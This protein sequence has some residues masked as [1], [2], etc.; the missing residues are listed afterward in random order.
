MK[1]SLIILIVSLLNAG[2]SIRPELGDLVKNMLVQT[3]AVE[4]IN[5]SNYVTFAI[6]SDTLGLLS[7][8]SEDTII[9]GNYARATTEKII[10]GMAQGGYDRVGIDEDPDLGIN[11]FILDNQGVFQSFN[12]PGNFGYPGYFFPGY[13][14]FGGP[15]GFGGYYG[16]PLVQ[17]FSYQTGT[18]VIELVD[19]KN[20]TPDNKLQ[21]VW[22]ARIGD[23]Y[24]SDDPLGNMVKAISQ[25][26]DQSQY[27]SR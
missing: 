11:A 20:R 3:S 26:F 22:V 6:P 25:A 14:G 9:T 4:N 5:F 10:E 18:M 17:N 7:N 12:Y 21:V 16:Y 27:L 8:V 13:Y 19:L 24:T 15:G 1:K 23:V 2:C